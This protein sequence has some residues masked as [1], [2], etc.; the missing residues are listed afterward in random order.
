MP[1]TDFSKWINL[2]L[3][4]VLVFFVSC[5]RKADKIKAEKYLKAC[6]AELSLHARNISESS[7]F[8][9]L[10]SFYSLPESPLPFRLSNRV[11]EQGFTGYDLA[12]A[13]GNYL[14]VND[15]SVWIR[16]LAQPIHCPCV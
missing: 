3:I 9:E 1:K 6:D 15:S 2:V 5:S 12:K 4:A 13:S 16:D 10:L 8:K 11:Y 7:G 14:F